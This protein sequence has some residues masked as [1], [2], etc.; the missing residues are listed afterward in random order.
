M[1]NESAG[2]LEQR[3]RDAIENRQR[4]RKNSFDTLLNILAVTVFVRISTAC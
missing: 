2:K 3:S 1:S 4:Y